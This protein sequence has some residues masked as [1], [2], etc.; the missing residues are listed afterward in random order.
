MAGAAKEIEVSQSVL[1][2]RDGIVLAAEFPPVIE[3]GNSVSIER[4][5]IIR[6]GCK[7]H[8]ILAELT[9]IKIGVDL[10]FFMPKCQLAGTAGDV[11]AKNTS[12]IGQTAARTKM[13]G[14]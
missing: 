4:P 8:V 11:R 7:G 12:I 5:G 3:H 10:G 9:R 2:D 6:L 13:E 14:G 1:S